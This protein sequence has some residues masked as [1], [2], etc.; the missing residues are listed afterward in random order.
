MTTPALLDHFDLASLDDLPRIEELLQVGLLS[1][2]A[3]L[4]G[5]QRTRSRTPNQGRPTR[6]HGL[7]AIGA[8]GCRRLGLTSPRGTVPASSSDPNEP[9]LSLRS[10]RAPLPNLPSPNRP[11]AGLAVTGLRHAF[12]RRRVVEDVSLV[13]LP[14]EVHC[15]VGPSGCGKTTILRLIAGLEP[16]QGGRIVMDG[17]IVA[18]PGYSL[19]P[20][21]R[22]VGLMFQDFALFPHLSVLDNV[23]F[24]LRGMAGKGRKRRAAS[25]SRRS[26]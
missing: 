18:E 19:A 16:L 12:G 8:P 13:I 9:E 4:R 20:E 5:R 14:A 11:P 25:C 1:S 24:G 23:A 22:R 7:P 15:L 3:P 21:A 2:G 17:V 10:W 26:T 6:M